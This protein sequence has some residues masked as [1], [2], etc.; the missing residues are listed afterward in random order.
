MS[1]RCYLEKC[2]QCLYAEF[3]IAGLAGKVRPGVEQ[4]VYSSPDDLIRKS[5]GFLTEVWRERLDGY[6]EGMYRRLADHFRGSDPYMSAIKKR[7]DKL[8]ALAE[9]IEITN[10]LRREAYC[11]NAGP[12]RL[13]LGLEPCGTLSLE[14]ASPPAP[15]FSE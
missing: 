7:R 6:F 12:L 14:N 1:D 4:P 3:E 2:Y 13:I 10:S 8:D 11:I 9:E 5:P 15:R